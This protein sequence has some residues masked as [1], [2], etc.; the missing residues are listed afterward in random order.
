LGGGGGKGIRHVKDNNAFQSK[1]VFEFLYPAMV[2]EMYPGNNVHHAS[3][4]AMIKRKFLQK[5]E[6]SRTFPQTS[7]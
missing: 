6:C 1:G 5:T 7:P 4:P 3:G 2:V